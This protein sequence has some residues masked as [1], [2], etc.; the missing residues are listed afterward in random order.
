MAARSAQAAASWLLDM[1]DWQRRHRDITRFLLSLLLLV[2]GLG[3]GGA[4]ATIDNYLHR[5]VET[6]VEIPYVVQPTGKELATNVDLRLFPNE[7]IGGVATEFRDSGFRYVRQEFAWSQIE[8]AEGTFDWEEY[9]LIVQAL[10]QNGIQVIAVVKDAPA[11]ARGSDSGQDG[12]PSDP[13]TFQTFMQE[14]TTHYGS[15]VPFVQIWDQPNLASQWG[16]TPA[17]ADAFIPLLAAGFNGARAGNA[18][19]KIITPELAVTPD[20]ASGQDDL[21]F[22]ASLFDLDAAPFFDIVGV[23]LDGGTLSPDDRR[24]APDRINVSR[25]ILYRDIVVRAGHAATPIWATSFGWSASGTVTRDRQ[26]DFVMRAMNRSW[27]EWPWMG[28]MVQWDFIDPDATSRNATYSVVLPDGH[29]TPLFR[30]LSSTATR[31]QASLANTGFAPMDSV[32]FSYAGSWQD[33]HLEGRT[34]KTTS[35]QGSSV[36]IRFRGTGVIAYIRSGPQ[37][38]RLQLTL[39]GNVISGG[40]GDDGTEWSFRSTLG[41]D[42]LPQ[43]LLSGLDD[44]DHVLTI[45]LAG[46]G[47]L[48]V[49]G[50]IIQR[51]APFLWPIVLLTVGA[52]ILI[53]MGVRSLAYLV[54]V[55]TGHLTRKELYDPAAQLQ[56]MPDWRPAR[57]A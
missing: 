51:D 48:T 43:Q 3:L 42:D 32:A 57:R 7:E 14:L 19:V 22:L 50:V 29:A 15:R 21:T 37:S 53:F 8:S 47:E 27:A 17:D 10:S 30:A 28:L 23:Q 39:D 20:A 46:N 1:L 55:R 12:P 52:L 13:A 24:V 45:T 36:T 18:E 9:D 41:T 49:G 38:G 16:G 34:F 54:A 5:G 31:D 40:Y 6:G 56:R 11:W 35:E 2:G 44:D 26:A 33:Q 4:A 25:A